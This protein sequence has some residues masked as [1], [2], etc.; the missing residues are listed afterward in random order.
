MIKITRTVFT[1]LC[2]YIPAVP[3]LPVAAQTA[4]YTTLNVK[5]RVQLEIPGDW[6][7]YIEGDQQALA[8]HDRLKNSIRIR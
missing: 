3:A 1:A 4:A 6:I 7:L 2:F 5:G 8:V